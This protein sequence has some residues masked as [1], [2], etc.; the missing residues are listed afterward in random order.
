MTDTVHY[1]I[2]LS[3]TPVCGVVNYDYAYEDFDRVTCKSCIKKY[4]KSMENKQLVAM[5][6]YILAKES[7]T[8]N[9]YIITTV[10]DQIWKQI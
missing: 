10:V 9:S 6:R 8:R 2:D 4:V 7:T 5:L 1:D 3:G